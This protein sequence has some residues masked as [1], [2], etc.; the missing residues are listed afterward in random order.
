MLALR[1]GAP[2]VPIGFIGTD[3]AQPVGSKMIWPFK[4]ITIRIGPPLDFS[5]QA[6]QPRGQ[7]VLRAMTD[8]VMAEIQRLSGQ[9]N[10]G[11][12]AAQDDRV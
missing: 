3:K 9:E 12:Y 11:R 4:R 5:A 1:T 8:S 6:D 2:V 7:R 10:T